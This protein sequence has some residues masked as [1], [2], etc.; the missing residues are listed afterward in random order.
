M[1]EADPQA[2][3]QWDEAGRWF[4]KADE[5]IRVVALSLAAVH[6]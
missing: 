3:T 5:D 4:A 2:L 6:P 1:S